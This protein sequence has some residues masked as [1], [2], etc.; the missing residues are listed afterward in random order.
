MSGAGG[1]VACG[2]V[3][4]AAAAAD[5]LRDGGNA[6]DAVV[7]AQCAACVAEPVLASLAG[8][9]F[10]LAHAA[11]RDPVVY[12]FF[13]STPRQK[14]P[15]ETLEFYPIEAAFVGAT[16]EFH[17]GLGA[18][19]T[20]GA[21]RGLFDIHRDLGSLPI[22]RLTQPAIDAARSGVE[23]SALQSRIFEIVRPIFT[24]TD[25]ARRVYAGGGDV[26][27][28]EGDILRQ[29]DLA[30]ALA[31]LTSEGPDLFYRG[32]LGA[33]LAEL[34]R[35]HGGLLRRDDLEGYQ[36]ERRVPLQLDYRQARVFTNPP[37]STGGPLIAFALH[38]LATRTRGHPTRWRQEVSRVLRLTNQA[39]AAA[40][41]SDVLHPE[42]LDRFRDQIS[43]RP[44]S[45]RGTTHISVIDAAGNLAAMTLSN[46][47]GCGHVLPGTGIML[48]NML[49]EQDLNPGG[50]HLWPAGVR[51]ASM[52]A[53]TLVESRGARYALGSG[54]SNRIRSAI[55]QV[56]DHLVT[57]GL[58]LDEAV[59]APRMHVEG[60]RMS[61]EAGFGAEV[62][63]WMRGAFPACDLWPQV[64]LF[65]GG[66]HAVGQHGGVFSAVGDP[67]RDGVGIVV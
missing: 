8:G 4:T 15:A 18:L 1:A 26:P 37:P 38:L 31:A 36:L 12:D 13:V 59:G 11:G 35:D 56:V 55:L 29:P 64:D 65:F 49:G 54:G 7:A 66:V 6:F 57:A 51:L 46:G 48:N 21:V 40:A 19:A 67:R 16:Q 28:A 47:E 14:K 3:V 24:A 5:V 25:E 42:L 62:E 27:P 10:L 63:R 20:P 34:C 60:D 23:T 32:E 33:R 9:G 41:D 53:P 2:H 45:S 44:R 61:L 58:P 17:I 30:D 52:M 50:F 22:A 39:R 43:G